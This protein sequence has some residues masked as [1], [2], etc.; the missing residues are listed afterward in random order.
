MLTPQDDFMGHQIATTFDHV[1]T[2]DPN[3]MERFW[4]TGHVAPAGDVIFDLGLGCYPNCNVMDAFAGVTIG[5]TQHNIRMSRRLRPDP[6]VTRVGPLQITVLEGLKRHRAVLEENSS[7]MSFEIEFNATMNPHEE[8]HHFRRRQGR[9]A[10]DLARAQ[11]LGRYSGWIKVAGRRFDLAPQSWWGQR[12]HSWG[13]RAEL[14]SDE[15][16]PPVT[17][18]PPFFYTWTTAQFADHG[19]QWFFNERAPGDFIY[20]TGEEVMPLGREPDRGRRMVSVAHD[21]KWADD[22]LG[23]T[24]KE[25]DMTLTFANGT[26]R[27]VHL[28]ALPAR[29]FLKSGMYGGYRGWFHGTDKGSSYVEHDVWD[30]N[31]PQI[32]RVARTLNDRVIEVREGQSV[33]YGI[34]E[35]GVSRGYPRYESVQQHPV[36]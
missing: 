11:Q 9:V 28:R 6:L 36:L 14:R 24:F 5:D 8:A 16:S 21:I 35:I 32:R 31:D 29:Y 1:A 17:H 3:W 27:L 23:Q 10:E 30:L 26:S 34:I 25:A 4:W 12:D 19:L 13:I 20:F 33:G 2:S 22:S 18:Y 7:G 15:S